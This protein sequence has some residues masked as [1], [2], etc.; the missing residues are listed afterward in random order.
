MK[1]KDPP[2]IYSALFGPKGV[3]MAPRAFDD[4]AGDATYDFPIILA[5]TIEGR[6]E[7][8]ISGLSRAHSRK[9]ANEDE[10]VLYLAGSDP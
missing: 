4:K 10:V 5:L 3:R 1:K 7:F 6:D 2:I 8:Y 9:F